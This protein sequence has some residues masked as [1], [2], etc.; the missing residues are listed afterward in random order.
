M[1][2]KLF[3]EHY[4]ERYLAS[5]RGVFRDIAEHEKF[6]DQISTMKPEGWV[7]GSLDAIATSSM[8]GRRIVMKAVNCGAESSTLPVRLQGA[9]V[10]EKASATLYSISAGLRDSASLDHPAAIA[11]VSRLVRYAKDLA[12]ELGGYTV[13]VLEIRGSE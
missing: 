5:T 8:D 6:L 7:P 1:V 4:A 3:R 2:E 11:P 9:G 13:A 12:V 10:P